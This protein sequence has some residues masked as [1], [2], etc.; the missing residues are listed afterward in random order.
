MLAAFNPCGI[1]LLP[2]YLA[3]FLGHD[4]RTGRSPVTR[5]LYVGGAVT[6]GFLIV[7]GLAGIAVSALAVTLKGR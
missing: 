4:D 3:I 7:F 5:A 6:L 1:A 2:T